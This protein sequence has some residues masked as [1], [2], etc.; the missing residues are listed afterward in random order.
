MRSKSSKIA[1]ALL[2]ILILGGLYYLL[3]KPSQTKTIK[4]EKTTINTPNFNADSAF[5]YVKTQVEFGPRVPNSSSHQ[6]FREYLINKLKSFGLNPNVQE[7]Q[8]NYRGKLTKGYNIIAQYQPN[9]GKRIL[10]AAHY[11]TRPIAD[12]DKE[13][14]KA[15]MD[16]ADDGASGVGVL[17]EIA[18]TISQS[19][20]PA[21]VGIDFI[22]FDLEDGGDA[23]TG[24][25]W[26]LGS[27]YWAS[28]LVPANYQAFYGVLLDMVGAKDAKFPFEAISMNYAPFV[29]KMI[30]NSAKELGYGNY[31]IQEQGGGIND[32]HVPV[33]Q[34]AK[35]QMI[36]I[37]NLKSG[38]EFPDHHHTKA[39]NLEIIDKNTLKA[40]GQTL[41]YTLYQE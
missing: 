28:N 2:I 21:K 13:N 8:V 9:F 37:I 4:E 36:D 38:Y 20:D 10:L 23:N 19:P 40:V 25:G 33:N 11:D 18:R 35:I 32:D 41:V 24:D 26:I 34:K 29:Q 39:D 14:P 30:W 12:K 3:D 31:F 16:G 6:L 17:L 27:D 15:A 7:F 5:N 1:L 22:F